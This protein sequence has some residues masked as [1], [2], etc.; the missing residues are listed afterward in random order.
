MQ[1]SHRFA[2]PTNNLYAALTKNDNTNDDDL[3]TPVSVLKQDKD[4][5]SFDNYIALKVGVD[6]NDAL[7]KNVNKVNNNNNNNNNSINTI[8]HSRE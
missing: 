4:D 1:L 5:N 3:Y 7:A 6:N 8:D 2:T